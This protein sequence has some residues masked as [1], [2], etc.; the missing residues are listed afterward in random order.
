MPE[1]WQH[2]VRAHL[3][4]AAAARL[5]DDPADPAIAPILAVLQR[6]RAALVSQL[7]AAR[8][9]SRLTPLN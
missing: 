6:H 4:E 5:R 1:A 7:D 3:T 2:Q 8:L 9:R